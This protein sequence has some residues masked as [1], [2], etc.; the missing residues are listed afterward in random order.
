[1]PFH[2]LFA[3]FL[4]PSSAGHVQVPLPPSLPNTTKAITPHL[5]FII[6]QHPLRSLQGQLMKLPLPPFAKHVQILGDLKEGQL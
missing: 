4:T 6:H 1:M 2:P 3:H 5:N